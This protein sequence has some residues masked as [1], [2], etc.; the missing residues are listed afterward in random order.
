MTTEEG[1]KKK[2][3]VIITDLLITINPGKFVSRSQTSGVLERFF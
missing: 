2:F 3:M 1:E